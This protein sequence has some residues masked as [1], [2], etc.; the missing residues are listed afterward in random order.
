MSPANVDLCF[1]HVSDTHFGPTKDFSIFGKTPF[2]DYQKVAEKI[3]ALTIPLD[4]VMHTGDVVSYQDKEA[5]QI[6]EQELGGLPK[7]QYFVA[8]NHDSPKLLKAFPLMGP[9]QD[10]LDSL[11]DLSYFFRIKNYLCIVLDTKH[12]DDAVP[13]GVLSPQVFSAFEKLLNSSNDEFLLFIHFPIPE[14]GAPWIDKNLRIYGGEKIHEMCVKHKKRCRGVFYGHIH[15]PT[16][17]TID[18][19]QYVSAASTSFQF[20]GWPNDVETISHEPE[21]PAGFSVVMVGAERT[22]VRFVAV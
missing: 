18:G 13:S 15:Q 6:A 8:G 9:K 7:P 16:I 11:G 19:I 10:L 1:L 12:P 3:R 17:N 5:Y 4:F 22:V 20:G 14:L 2:L 21:T